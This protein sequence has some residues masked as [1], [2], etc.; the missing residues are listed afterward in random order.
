ML[1]YEHACHG[2][3]DGRIGGDD[4]GGGGGDSEGGSGDVVAVVVAMEVGVGEAVVVEP[5]SATSIPVVVA[6]AVVVQVS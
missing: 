6:A 4:S 2:S 1:P 3:S 5:I